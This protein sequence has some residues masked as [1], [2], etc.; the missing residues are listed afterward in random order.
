M[1]D[2]YDVELVDMTAIA[3]RLTEGNVGRVRSWRANSDRNDFPMPLVNL[4]IG[5]VWDMEDLYRWWR[6][7]ARVEADYIRAESEEEGLIR[8]DCG[9]DIELEE[10]SCRCGNLSPLIHLSA[11]STIS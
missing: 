3:Y 2:L 9:C 6:R 11:V 7:R 10:R 8:L 5:P 1:P 4:N